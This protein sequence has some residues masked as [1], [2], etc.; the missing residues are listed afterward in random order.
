MKYM[1]Y[2]KVDW[3]NYLCR[4]FSSHT[5]LQSDNI[6][7]SLSGEKLKKF[8]WERTSWLSSKVWEQQTLCHILAVFFLWRIHTSKNQFEGDSTG[9][10]IHKFKFSLATPFSMQ[11]PASKKSLATPM[12]E[13]EIPWQ[14]YERTSWEK[15]ST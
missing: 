15:T 14:R 8:P 3:N 1:S 11:N 4:L 12:S 13:D 2:S 5:N 7:A 6:L 9:R 10:R